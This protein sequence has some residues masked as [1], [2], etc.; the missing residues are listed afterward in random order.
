M[1]VDLEKPNKLAILRRSKNKNMKNFQKLKKRD[2]LY[3][4][5]LTM[6][7]TATK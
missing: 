2:K 3:T 4:N 5:L 6:H 7:L 1:H